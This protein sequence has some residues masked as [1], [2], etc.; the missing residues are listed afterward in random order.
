[1]LLTGKLE[2]FLERKMRGKRPLQKGTYFSYAN[3]ASFQTKSL[4]TKTIQYG[5]CLAL[6]LCGFRVKMN[7]VSVLV[8]F[9]WDAICWKNKCFSAIQSHA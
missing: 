1:M 9:L 7:H 2:L 4:K 8:V 5:P 6:H 3:E